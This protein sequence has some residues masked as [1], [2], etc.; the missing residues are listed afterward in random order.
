MPGIADWAILLVLLRDRQWSTTPTALL[1]SWGVFASFVL[2][3]GFNLPSQG[4][5]PTHSWI[6]VGLYVFVILL[7]A[8]FWRPGILIAVIIHSLILFW[9]LKPL[10]FGF[11]RWFLREPLVEVMLQIDR[12]THHKSRWITFGDWKI[13]NLPRMIGIPSLNGTFFEPQFNMWNEI[14]EFSDQDAVNRYAHVIFVTKDGLPAVISSPIYDNILV[15]IDP[16]HPV[17]NTW[18]ITHYLVTGENSF[19][20]FQTRGWKPI[21]EHNGR[22]IFERRR[23]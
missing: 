1:W 18:K 8:R 13:A 2:Y 20:E 10:E 9:A 12:Q 3:I 5:V 16:D 22:F 6:E 19:K 17:M 4:V 21:F 15:K 11:S 14:K 7:F 23:L